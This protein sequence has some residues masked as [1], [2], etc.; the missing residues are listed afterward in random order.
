MLVLNIRQIDSLDLTTLKELTFE[1]ADLKKFKCIYLAY[2]ALK[3]GGSAA[4][5]LLPTMVLP[6]YAP[7][8]SNKP[9]KI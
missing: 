7:R 6:C 2:E 9:I 1:K 5:V 3:I 4:A 8:T